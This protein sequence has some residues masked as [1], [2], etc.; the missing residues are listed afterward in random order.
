MDLTIPNSPAIKKSAPRAEPMPEP[1]H[2]FK[3]NPLKKS[4]PFVPT[5]VHQVKQAKDVK[6]PGDAIREKKMKDFESKVQDAQ[7]EEA[8]GRLFKARPIPTHVSE[9]SP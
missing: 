7:A 9:V 6:L 5:I 1:E 3:A 4:E 8:R 2:L